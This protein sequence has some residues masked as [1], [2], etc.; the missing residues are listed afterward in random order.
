MYIIHLIF[1]GR[2]LTF[3]IYND[4]NTKMGDVRH[5]FSSDDDILLGYIK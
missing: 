4:V 1:E 5:L 3:M 2:N